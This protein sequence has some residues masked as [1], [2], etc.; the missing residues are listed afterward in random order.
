MI[1][2]YAYQKAMQFRKTYFNNILGL[3]RSLIAFI[4]RI[5]AKPVSRTRGLKIASQKL[6]WWEQSLFFIKLGILQ[7]V[8]AK[9]DVQV[10]WYIVRIG[11]AKDQLHF[12]DLQ[13]N[14]VQNCHYLVS[15]ELWVN[16]CKIIMKGI[17]R[18]IMISLG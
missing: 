8:N 16:K 11:L 7:L 9:L 2:N 1:Y 5:M 17:Y 15:N 10:E 3:D 18:I 12:D 4:T 14:A 13:S 6:S